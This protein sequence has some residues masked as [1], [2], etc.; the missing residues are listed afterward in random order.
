[1]SFDEVCEGRLSSVQ[2]SCWERFLPCASLWV[3]VVS[4]VSFL[5]LMVTYMSH[6]LCI[7]LVPGKGCAYEHN[8]GN[9]SVIGYAKQ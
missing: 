4:C 2:A 6:V 9:P 5:A 8:T 3:V 7:R 1:M